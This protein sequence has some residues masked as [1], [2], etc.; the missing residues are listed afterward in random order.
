MQIVRSR[1]TCAELGADPL[2]GDFR[3]F[4]VQCPE[5]GDAPFVFSRDKALEYLVF[6]DGLSQPPARIVHVEGCGCAGGFDGTRFHGAHQGSQPGAASRRLRIAPSTPGVQAGVRAIE[7]A[8]NI[9]HLARSQ[10]GKCAL[11]VIRL[12][13]AATEGGNG[14]VQ[15]RKSAQHLLAS[16]ANDAPFVQLMRTFRQYPVK[17]LAYG[18]NFGRRQA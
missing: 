8:G 11:Y 12:V 1:E 17:C 13:C 14:S 5:L 3:K 18:I 2:A 15:L 10:L 7:L 4:V 9:G 16:V 6:I